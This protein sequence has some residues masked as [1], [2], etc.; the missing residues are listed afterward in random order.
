[1]K[2]EEYWMSLDTTFFNYIEHPESKFAN[3]NEKG[4]LKRRTITN[5]RIK[6]VGKEVANIEEGLDKANNEE[7]DPT[8]IGDLTLKERKEKKIS[9][10]KAYYWRKKSIN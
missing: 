2:G 8:R 3:G 6:H 5:P 7:Q 9:R 1:M 4:E 10:Q